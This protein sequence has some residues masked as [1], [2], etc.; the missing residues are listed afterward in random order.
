MYLSDIHKIIQ[1]L[2][3]AP[4]SKKRTGHQK[5]SHVVLS[6]Y[7]MPVSGELTPNTIKMNFTY[8][9]SLY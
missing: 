4:E 9:S 8:F 2:S 5:V 3:L 1:P 7:H 6:H